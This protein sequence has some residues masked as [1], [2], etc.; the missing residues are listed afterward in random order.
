MIGAERCIPVGQ[1]ADGLCFWASRLSSWTF[2]PDAKLLDLIR[3][4]WIP[5][6]HKREQEGIPKLGVHHYLSSDA[7]VV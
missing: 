1:C 5:A 7:H 6:G 3:R 4:T 2:Y